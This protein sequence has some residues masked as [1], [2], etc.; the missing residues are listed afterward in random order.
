MTDKIPKIIPEIFV[1]ILLSLFFTGKIKNANPEIIIRMPQI[2]VNDGISF[3]KITPN[4]PAK[5]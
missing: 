1:L 5:K 3:K 2:T 4:K